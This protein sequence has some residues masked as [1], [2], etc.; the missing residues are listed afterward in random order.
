[1]CGP[2]VTLEIGDWRLEIGISNLQSPIVAA[3]ELFRQGKIVAVKGL[4][5]FHLACDAT[6]EEAV[7][8]L[9]KRKGRI[10]KPFALMMPDVETV[11]HYCHVSSEE[12]ALRESRQRPIV[13]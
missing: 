3:Q 11:E 7:A 12:R 9:R 8:E 1:K 4:G 13:L 10:D 5:G 2:K 6:N